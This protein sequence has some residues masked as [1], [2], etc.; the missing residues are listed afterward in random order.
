MRQWLVD[1]KLLCDRHLLGEH[2]E[3]HMFL[4]TLKKKVSIKGYIEKGLLQVELL[5]SR[6]DEL[7]EEM[8]K[9]GMVHKSP[10]EIDF[11]LWQEG[12]ISIEN[13]IQELK[14]RCQECRKRIESSEAS[15]I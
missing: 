15:I 6:H 13:N 3:S 10:F 11:P 7:V 5:K 1:P 4:G 12:S 14:R 8:E 2:V 9:R